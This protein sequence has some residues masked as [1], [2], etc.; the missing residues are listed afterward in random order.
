QLNVDSC[1]ITG[2]VTVSSAPMFVTSPNL[3]LNGNML[4][5]PTANGGGTYLQ[6][7]QSG[8][9]LGAGTITLNANLSNF[10]TAYVSASG[11]ATATMP[12]GRAL[13][14]T[15]RTYGKIAFGGVV[16]PSNYSTFSQIGQLDIRGPFTFASTS[17]FEADVASPSSFD[18]ITGDGTKALNGTLVLRLLNGF[19]ARPANVL[20]II[21]GSAARTGVFDSIVPPTGYAA[22]PTYPAT[23]LNLSLARTCPADLNADVVV[24]DADFSLFVVAYDILDC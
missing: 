1:S 11:N 3:T 16:S 4:I 13:K 9:L 23:G 15:G 21:S 19:I 14:G 22:V 5:N 12:S 17:S 8:S 20:P 7:N 6:F 10:D 2:D 18:R 24:D